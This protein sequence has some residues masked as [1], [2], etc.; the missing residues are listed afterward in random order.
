MKVI[1]RA[2]AVLALASLG[3]AQDTVNGPKG[4]LGRLS[5]SGV[6]SSVDFTASGSTAPVKTG[7]LAGRPTGCTLGQIYFATDVSAGQNLYVCTAT[8]APGTWT[9]H[10]GGAP[11]ISSLIS[12]PDSTRTIAGATHG[13]TT[14]ALL[15]AV[16]DNASPRNAIQVAWTVNASTY[17]VT[18][19]FATPQSNYYVVIN[20]GVGPA[21][22]SGP[23]GSS[24]ACT[25]ASA[26]GFLLNGTDETTLLNSTLAAFYTAGGGCLAIDPNKTLRAD[27][28]ITLPAATAGSIQGVLAGPQPPYRITGYAGAAAGQPGLVVGGSVLDL[29]YH[30]SGL[31][32][33]QGGPKLLSVGQGMLEID[34]ITITTGAASD[35]ATF[36]M[37]TGT[38]PYFHDMAIYGTGCNG[39]IVIAGTQAVGTYAAN[40]PLSTAVTGW[41]NGYGG[42]IENVKLFGIGNATAPGI[43]LQSQVNQFLIRHIYA[44]QGGSSTAWLLSG[45]Q[46]YASSPGAAISIVGHG[47][48]TDASRSNVIDEGIIELGGSHGISN[49]YNCGVKLQNAEETTI[50]NLGFY[51]GNS[52]TAAFCGDATATKS[53]VSSTNYLDTTGT[54]YTNGTWSANNNM[55][56]RAVTF[57]F[58]GGGSALT[59]TTTRCSAPLAF[60]GV[61]NRFSMYADQ[62]GNATVTVKTVLAGSYTGPASAS[63]ISNGGETM[64]GAA[65]L[66]D[67]TLTGWANVGLGSSAGWLQPNSIV[68]FI[69]SAPSTITWLQGNI[70]LL[71]GR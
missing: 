58:D 42:S 41:F 3:N 69:L 34:H 26:L 48:G 13:F 62:S 61:I 70:Q 45:G 30:G 21:G 12:G 66:S 19:A 15:V 55:P 49:D 39:G 6:N 25:L 43:L 37:T 67:T 56:Y 53:R 2:L 52:G 71:E 23:S 60:G 47:T 44:Q 24:G 65:S 4:V 35:C 8:G 22:P 33:F 18:I 7:T 16:Y 20:G 68:C 36:L 14:T 51:D 1:T 50:T 28:Q 59:G 63:D 17:D 46:T 5:S 57:S 10:G 27:G 40:S 38:T 29:R 32:A 54:V 11:Y 64:T 9:L 31:A